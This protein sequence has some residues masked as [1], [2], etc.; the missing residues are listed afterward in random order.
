MFT[1]EREST[2][3]LFRS[4]QESVKPN[5]RAS[6]ALRGATQQF[7]MENT[8]D[9]VQ[10]VNGLIQKFL[11]SA[12]PSTSS[13]TKVYTFGSSGLGAAIAGSDIDLYGETSSFSLLL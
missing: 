6:E 4:L 11:R 8:G 7:S 1:M 10:L 2:S 5:A 13:W 3:T 9:V 12:L